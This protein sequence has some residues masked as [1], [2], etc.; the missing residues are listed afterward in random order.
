MP[1]VRSEH[2]CVLCCRASECARHVILRSTRSTHSRAG[3]R[4]MSVEMTGKSVLVTGAGGFIGSHLTEALVHAGAR[5]RALVHYNSR[6]DWG[7]IESLDPRAREALEVMAGDVRDPFYVAEATKGVEVIFHLAAL[8][9]IP[10]SY[11]APQEYVDT[12]V[13]GTLNVLE[14]VRRH[15]TSRVLH[16]STSETYGTAL[17]TPI[18]EKHPL[19]AQSPYSASKIGADKLAE[20]FYCSFDLPVTTIRPFNTYG[21]YQSARAVI[22]TIISQAFSNNVIKLGS[23]TPI[24]DLTFIEDTVSGFI[25]VAESRSEEHTSE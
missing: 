4:L 3:E 15:G 14:A 9:P 22:P 24:R 5:V 6:S 10:Y 11:K 18:D 19:Q 12:N 13:R 23:L 20:S 16:T 7:H 8:I 21:P 2:P 1:V 17:Y 25:R